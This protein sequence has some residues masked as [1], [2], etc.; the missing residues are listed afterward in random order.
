MFEIYVC[1]SDAESW[2][3]GGRHEAQLALGLLYLL[4]CILIAWGLFNGRCSRV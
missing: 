3:D 2:S 1:M 4:H